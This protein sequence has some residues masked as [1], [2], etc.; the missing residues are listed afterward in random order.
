MSEFKIGPIPPTGDEIFAL[1]EPG[2]KKYLEW[3]VG[4][5]N[6]Y[7]MPSHYNKSYTEEYV[8]GYKNYFSLTLNL[9][10]E[11]PLPFPVLTEPQI[12]AVAIVAYEYKNL[13]PLIRYGEKFVDTLSDTYYWLYLAGTKYFYSIMEIEMYRRRVTTE[14]KLVDLSTIEMEYKK[15][16]YNI[17][18]SVIWSSSKDHR[19]LSSRV[20]TL[21]HENTI[22]TNVNMPMETI[23]HYDPELI[24][25]INKILKSG[26]IIAG[27]FVNNLINPV[28]KTQQRTCWEL[29]RDNDNEALSI[30]ENLANFQVE[31]KQSYNGDDESPEEGDE[32]PGEDDELAKHFAQ[33]MKNITSTVCVAK[34]NFYADGSQLYSLDLIKSHDMD[35]FITGGD[36]LEKTKRILDCLLFNGNYISSIYNTESSISIT[37]NEIIKVQIIKRAYS[38]VE[39]IL[40]GFDLNPS[41]VALTLGEGDKWKF[42]APQ[43]YIDAVTYGVNVVVPCW[44]SETFNSRL[45]KYRKKGFDIYLPGNIINRHGLTEE[46][47]LNAKGNLKELITYIGDP[48]K[49]NMRDLSDYDSKS[50]EYLA[51]TKGIVTDL[52]GIEERADLIVSGKRA[53]GMSDLFYAINRILRR[54]YHGSFERYKLLIKISCLFWRTTDPTTQLTGSFNPTKLDYLSG[55]VKEVTVRVPSAE[56][57]DLIAVL[58]NELVES[59]GFLFKRAF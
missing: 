11:T 33:M 6:G 50:L 21:T 3:L 26:G 24:P 16:G 57:D 15:E 54:F 1:G 5:A 22:N 49:W 51:K 35:I 27:G 38:S 34:Q 40:A 7:L 14:L 42:V 37:L 10:S 59:D 30:P 55:E 29:T 43:A 44:Q 53:P 48:H 17:F 28:Y 25:L 32:S 12:F 9:L 36:Y 39:E 2:L 19:F 56:N 8:K 31:R 47:D 52:I 58:Y 18:K 41:K 13:I 20:N 4:N 45:S 46:K 23:H